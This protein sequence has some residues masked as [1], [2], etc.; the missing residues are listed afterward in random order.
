MTEIH[1]NLGA[2]PTMVAVRDTLIGASKQIIGA[3]VDP[4]LLARALV[5]TG[6]SLAAA[7]GGPDAT[8]TLLADEIQAM[9]AVAAELRADDTVD[10]IA[11]A[12]GAKRAD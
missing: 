2:N 9:D 10:E 8:K 7:V 12:A 6:A 3:G 4:A 11:R 1:V 5:N